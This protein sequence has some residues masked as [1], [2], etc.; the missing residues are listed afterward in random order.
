MHSWNEGRNS[1]YP[2]RQGAA[3]RHRRAG[4]PGP[5]WSPSKLRALRAPTPPPPLPLGVWQAIHSARAR[6]YRKSGITP[7]G[8]RELGA[9]SRRCQE[10]DIPH[11]PTPG[12]CGAPKERCQRARLDQLRP[13]PEMEKALF[14]T[15]LAGRTE[16]SL[17]FQVRSLAGQI[18]AN[19]KGRAVRRS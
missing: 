17:W 9:G 13:G 10:R 4:S 19:S 11:L 8:S 6:R 5:R 12:R 16:L 3:S 1:H 2:V 15:A 7:G 14:G 18:Q